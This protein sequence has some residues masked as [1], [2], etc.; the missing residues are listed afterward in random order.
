LQV[1]IT[2]VGQPYVKDKYGR[3]DV[4]Y[5]RDGKTTEKTLTAVGDTKKAAD[6]IAAKGPG[7]YEIKMEK[8]AK[9]DK[10]F[11]NWVGAEQL[12][13]TAKSASSTGSTASTFK[14]SNTYETA[15]ERVK[16][17][18]SI[19]RQNA[20]GNAL[21]YHKDSNATFTVVDVLDT[22]RRFADFINDGL[23]G[24]PG[25][26]TKPGDGSHLAKAPAGKRAST[27]RSE[28]ED[29]FEDDIPF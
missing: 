19:Q 1:N 12:E 18:L 11:W 10:E 27:K 24:V 6:V 22:A 15:E 29:D 7:A 14:G 23:Y 3:L 16:K 20:L 5:E 2:K 21:I 4:T 13:A 8:V 26:E 25:M 28:A 9:G 17:N